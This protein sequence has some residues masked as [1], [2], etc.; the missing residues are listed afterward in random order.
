MI[1]PATMVAL[2]EP[3]AIHL[4]NSA[5]INTDMQIGMSV[6]ESMEWIQDRVDDFDYVV[7]FHTNFED[8][9]TLKW[10]KGKEMAEEKQLRFTPSDLTT[11]FYLPTASLAHAM[12]VGFGEGADA[13]CAR[14]EAIAEDGPDEVSFCRTH[15]TFPKL[16]EFQGQQPSSRTHELIMPDAGLGPHHLKNAMRRRA[17]QLLRAIA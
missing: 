10:I 3:F 8:L 15:V 7:C 16:F 11:C 13:D 12:L 17:R 5:I 14:Q 6:D 4:R 1:S 2:T 9:S